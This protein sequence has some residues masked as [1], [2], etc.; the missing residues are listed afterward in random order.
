VNANNIE[1]FYQNGIY[2]AISFTSGETA[3]VTQTPAQVL[4]AIVAL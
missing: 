2:T 3:E 4:A 1:T